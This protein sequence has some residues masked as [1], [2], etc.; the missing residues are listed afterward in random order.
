MVFML[1]YYHIKVMDLDTIHNRQTVR[2]YLNYV[3]YVWHWVFSLSVS[4]LEQG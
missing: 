3:R 4:V 2:P 1:L